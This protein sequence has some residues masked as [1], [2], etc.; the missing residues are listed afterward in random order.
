MTDALGAAFAELDA[1]R[2]AALLETAP[3]GLGLVDPEGRVVTANPAFLA[4]VGGTINP[5][6]LVPDTRRPITRLAEIVDG[7]PRLVSVRVVAS[8]DRGVAAGWLLVYVTAVQEQEPVDGLLALLDRAA[9]VIVVVDRRTTVIYINQTVTDVLR[10]HPDE[11]VGHSALDFIHR[12]DVPAAAA[13]LGM[14]LD[15]VEDIPVVELRTRHRNGAFLWFE[16]VASGWI[17]APGIRGVVLNLR[18][19]TER[20]ELASVAKRRAELDRVVFD[21]SRKA[22]DATLADLTA[23]LPDVLAHLGELL[24]CHRA[25]VALIDPTRPSTVELASW[26]AAELP[27]PGRDVEGSVVARLPAVIDLLRAGRLLAEDDLADH[28]PPWAEEWFGR[29]PRPGA[30]VLCPLLAEG[31]LLGLLALEHVGGARPWQPDEVNAVHAAGDALAVALARDIDRRALVASEERFR[32]MAE[33]ASDAIVVFEPTGRIQYASPAAQ[34]ILGMAP[35]SLLGHRLT[36]FVHAADRAGIET[37]IHDLATGDEVAAAMTYRWCKPQ[38]DVAWVENVCRVLRDPASGSVTTIQGATRDVT[39][40]KAME[41]ELSRLALFD[42]LTGAAN[43]TLFLE[44]LSKALRARHRSGGPVS[45][46]VVDLDGFKDVNDRYGHQAGDQALMTVAKRLMALVR[47]ADTVARVGGD[48]FVV[49]CHD[50]DADAAKA[51]AER[52]VGAV[53]EPIAVGPG[54]VQ[55]GASIG[56]A[57]ADIGEPSLEALLRAADVAMY[58]AKRAGKGCVRLRRP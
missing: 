15:G 8:P 43:R 55:V 28:P 44:R 3:I 52:L 22:L 38:G 50:A 7:V 20:H 21:V 26:V 34:A 9:D 47:P 6:W 33:N 46:L 49:L 25:Y 36:D 4:L 2:V 30:S 5:E 42:P 19:C 14:A 18:E 35:D 29:G 58:E 1:A 45:V 40:R 54:L 48:E 53:G 32:L 12:D 31:Q 10:W 17:D 13:A 51:L 57:P 11:V 27:R 39:A 41:E 16:A 24:D 23:A 37:R 56:V